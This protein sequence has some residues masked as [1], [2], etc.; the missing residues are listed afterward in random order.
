MENIRI[1]DEEEP[2]KYQ[3]PV[4][5]AHFRYEDVYLR[6]QY[7]QQQLKYDKEYNVDLKSSKEKTQAQASKNTNVRNNIIKPGTSKSTVR[8]EQKKMSKEKVPQKKTEPHK[9]PTTTIHTL[10]KQAKYLPNNWI[11]KSLDKRQQ[12]KKQSNGQIGKV[13]INKPG[14][15]GGYLFTSM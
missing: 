2:E 7:L 4:T 15:S 5:G 11:N 1:E 12:K 3:D 8:K 9:E 6:L 10:Y 14:L 13:Q